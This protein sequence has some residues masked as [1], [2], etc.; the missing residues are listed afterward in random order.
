VLHFR[1]ARLCPSSTWLTGKESGL[2]NYCPL[3]VHYPSTISS[4]HAENHIPSADLSDSRRIYIIYIYI[5]MTLYVSFWARPHKPTIFL[6]L[7]FIKSIISGPGASMPSSKCRGRVDS[8]G[9]RG[10]KCRGRAV[11]WLC[12]CF[13][14]ERKLMRPPGVA[15]NRV[16]LIAKW[17][18]NFWAPL[19]HKMRILKIE[20]VWVDLGRALVP[21]G[22]FWISL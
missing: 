21:C 16:T 5:Y 7:L 17:V 20:G 8:R 15:T 18:D 13:V 3:S 12:G 22:V 11:W 2:N 19:S 6:I 1:S 14:Y 9:A 10:S 4:S